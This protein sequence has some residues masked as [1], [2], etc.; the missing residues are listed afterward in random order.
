[1]NTFDCMIN[2]AGPCTCTCTCTF[3]QRMYTC[4]YIV[5]NCNVRIWIYIEAPV[6][7]GG[8]GHGGQGGQGA[9]DCRSL[10]ETIIT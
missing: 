7:V 9:C 10:C 5:P 1:M 4:M 2:L 3:H 8:A 6:E